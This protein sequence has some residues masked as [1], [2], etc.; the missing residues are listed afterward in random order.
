[1]SQGQRHF[2]PCG[3]TL[4]ESQW[5]IPAAGPGQSV[6]FSLPVRISGVGE[7]GW[8]EVR[9]LTHREALERESIGTFEECELSQSGAIIS[10]TRRLDLWAMA[11]YDYTL[12]LTDFLLPIVHSGDEVTMCRMGDRD[13]D[14]NVA[15]LSAMPTALADWVQSCI[16]R[17]N[18]RDE[19]GQACLD[20]AKKNCGNCCAGAAAP[21]ASR[22]GC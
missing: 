10:V 7:A 20:D 13:L 21:V 22:D 16:D 3:D 5:I 14:A 6:R 15:L 9:A 17:A 2:T 11:Q 19:T 1:M 4:D 18:L 12:A 8:V